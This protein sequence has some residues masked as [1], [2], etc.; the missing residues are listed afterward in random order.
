MLLGLLI[1]SQSQLLNESND[2]MVRAC[3][4]K[5][6]LE[7]QRLCKGVFPTRPEKKRSGQH[8]LD[9]F[10]LKSFGMEPQED[11][12]MLDYV[13]NALTARLLSGIRHHRQPLGVADECC[14]KP[15]SIAT[16]REYCA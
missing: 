8:S 12:M 14:K 2:R 4:Y 1:G 7:L 11:I 5:L 15:C 3:G 10:N 9:D 16:M 13:D 6:S